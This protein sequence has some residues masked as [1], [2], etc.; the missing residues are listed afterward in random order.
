MIDKNEMFRYVKM[1]FSDLI[2]FLILQ[3]YYDTRFLV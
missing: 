2:F 1:I 3:E